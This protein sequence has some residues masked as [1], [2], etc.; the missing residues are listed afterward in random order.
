MLVDVVLPLRLP[1]SLTYELPASLKALPGARLLVPLGRR[2][3]I[4]C[5]L[6]E[7]KFPPPQQLKKVQEVLPEP[8]L[9]PTQIKLMVWASHYYLTPMGE[10]LKHLIPP[11]LLNRKNPLIRK[12]KA[13]PDHLHFAPDRPLKLNP[14]QEEIVSRISSSSPEPFLLHGITGSGKTEIYIELARR[15]IEQGGQ[16]LVLVPEIALTPQLIG[17]FQGALHEPVIPYHSGLTQGQRLQAWLKV[18]SGEARLVIGTRSAVFLP[19]TRLALIVVDEEHDPSYKQQ[20]RFCYHARDLALW[21]GKEERAT[22]LLGTATPSLESLYRCQKGKLNL[23]QLNSRPEQTTLPTVQIIDR[24]L[25]ENRQMLSDPLKK[26]LAETLNRKEQSL[27][28]LNRRGF[29]PFL[30]CHSC[31][32]IPRCLGC[33]ISL[34]CHKKQGLLLCHYCDQ[35]IPL[36]SSC[37]RCHLPTITPEGFGTERIEEELKTLFPRARIARLDRDTSSHDALLKILGA[38]KKRELDILVG[39]QTVTK[40]HDYPYLTLVG[41]I[42]ADTAL[43][44]PDFRASERT[45]QLLTQVAGRSGRGAREGRVMIQTYHPDHPGLIAAQQQDGSRFIQSE[46]AHREET[47]YPPFTRL[48]RIVLSGSNPTQVKKTAKLVAEKIARLDTRPHLIGPAPCPLTKIRGK[49]RWHLL[50]KSHQ[51]TKLH[52]RLQPAL[53][54]IS[55]NSLPSGVRMMVDVDPV[56]MM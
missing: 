14:E 42:D 31:G 3:V 9:T 18:R 39:T 54:E 33:E 34:T 55:R 28:F 40:G 32:F 20:E 47:N 52:A 2:L 45:F 46:F 49:E 19:L 5:L 50:I 6:A 10:V 41:I 17:R 21:R 12:G 4:G 11:P 35:K 53:D 13:L 43:N 7:S 26:A 25:K 51:F 29:A 27:L 36:P 30:I 23:L 1:G 22:V 8:T 44:L 48:I 16:V 37:P 56:E 24:R 15:L 38:M